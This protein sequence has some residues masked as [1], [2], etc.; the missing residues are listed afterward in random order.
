[1]QAAIVPALYVESLLGSLDAGKLGRRY[2]IP[3]VVVGVV[4]HR[5]FP[6]FRQMIWGLDG[7]AL[8]S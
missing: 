5:H 8:D 1:M 6:G 4:L 3:L 7:L 2:R